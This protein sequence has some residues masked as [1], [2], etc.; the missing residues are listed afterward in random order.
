M[1]VIYYMLCMYCHYLSL[2]K[3]ALGIVIINIF[4]YCG[5]GL[6]PSPAVAVI[7]IAQESLPP[8]S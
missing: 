6:T 5:I 8:M 7:V 4:S 2:P 3:Q 1:H